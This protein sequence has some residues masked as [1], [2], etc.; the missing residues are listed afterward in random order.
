[1]VSS[2]DGFR[3]PGLEIKKLSGQKGSLKNRSPLCVEPYYPWNQHINL[4]RDNRNSA[5]KLQKRRVGGGDAISQRFSVTF[6][7]AV[8][9][10]LL[11]EYTLKKGKGYL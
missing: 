11:P 5:G 6:F 8:H 4:K 3:G 7:W 9:P 2:G 10:L 1:M